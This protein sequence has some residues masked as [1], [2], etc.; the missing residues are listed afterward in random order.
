MKIFSS[1]KASAKLLIM[2]GI[3]L[4]L[5]LVGTVWY[6]YATI[7]RDAPEIKRVADYRPLGV[8]Q[9]LSIDNG[10]SKVMAEYYKEKRYLVPYDQIPK[11]VVSAFLSAEDSTFFEHQGVNFVAIARAAVANF[12]AGQV[13]QG[14]STITQQI[15]KSLYLSPERNILRKVKELFLAFQLEK[16]LSKEEILYLYLNQIYLGSGSYGVQA[17]ARTYFHKDLKQLTVAEMAIIAGMP[18]APGKFSPLLNPKRAKE[19]QMYVL[20]RMKENKYITEAEQKAAGLER[21]KIY[22]NDGTEKHLAPHFV[23]HIRRHLIQKYGEKAVYEEGLTVIVPSAAKYFEFASSALEAGLEEYDQRKG[24][25]GPIKNI[26]AKDWDATREELKKEIVKEYFPFRYLTEHGSL[27]LEEAIHDYDPTYEKTLVGQKLKAVVTQIAG[28]KKSATVNVGV[29]N[30][31]LPFEWV[32][33]A[34]PAANP[35]KIPKSVADVLHPGDE[36]WVKVLGRGNDGWKARLIQLPEVEGALYSVDVNTGQILAMVGGYDYERSQFNRAVQ[37][38]RQIGST[39]KPIIYSAALERGYT[40]ASIIVDAPIVFEDSENG[41]WKPENYEEKFYGDTTFRQALIHSRNIP[42]VKIVQDIKVSTV[43]AEAKRMG[44]EGPFNND[45]SISLGSANA[46]L[47]DMV[48]A[49]TAFPLQGKPFRAVLFDRIL[50]RDGRVLETTRD[51]PAEKADLNEKIDATVAPYAPM[52]PGL[53][54]DPRVAYVMSHLMKEVVQFGT[55][56]RASQFDHPIA[57]KT[58][59]TQDFRDAWFMGFSPQVV[60]GVWVGYDDQRSL[61]HGETG[62][63]VSLPIWMNF[64]EKALKNYPADDFAIPEGIT[65][66]N[67]DPKTGKRSDAS[68]SIKEAFI[69]GTEPGSKVISNADV[70]TSE[71]G[72]KAIPKTNSIPVGNTDDETLREEN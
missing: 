1:I 29:I 48:H 60:T 72:K 54:L 41:V 68:T 37:A 63:N 70:S 23:E 55:A 33:W 65:F 57:G 38:K 59:T 39:F 42:T 11:K 8:T 43:I 7:S 2:T 62:A 32:R 14:G 21:V 13:V 16:Y 6:A 50:D 52:V 9:I 25:R 3:V 66:A 40:P 46:S 18:T 58:G 47:Q 30:L 53:R 17:A 35:G 34:S 71:P 61:G 4:L 20:K 5:A 19:R 45:L 28:D 64:M 36:V 51:L 56:T 12:L 22:V 26:P 31:T 10:Q 49:F 24:Y 69:T 27:D 67:I 15:A 44:L